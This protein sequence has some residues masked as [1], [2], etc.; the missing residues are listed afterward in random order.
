MTNRTISHILE[1]ILKTLASIERFVDQIDFKTFQGD[2]KT[3]RATIRE[4]EIMEEA[5]KK[6]QAP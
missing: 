1:D 5:V 2:E 4:F 3:I 6:F